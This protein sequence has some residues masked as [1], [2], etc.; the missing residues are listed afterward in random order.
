MLVPDGKQLHNSFGPKHSLLWQ[1]EH[2]AIEYISSSS[3]K[4]AR[5]TARAENLRQARYNRDAIVAYPTTNLARELKALLR[6]SSIA[7]TLH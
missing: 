2:L 1:Q 6:E 3:I 7:R 4:R 5:S